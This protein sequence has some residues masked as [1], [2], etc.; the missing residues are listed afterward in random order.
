[1]PRDPPVTTAIFPSSD[2]DNSRRAGLAFQIRRIS[3]T[4][5][6]DRIMATVCIMGAGELGGAVAHALAQR[7]RVARVVLIDP[8]ARVAAG[9]ALDIQ[10]AGAVEGF[11]T[12][13]SGTDD[14]TQVTGCSICVLADRSGSPPS[15]WIGDEGLAMLNR[16]AGYLGRAPIVC[17]GAN[18][19][20]L[21]M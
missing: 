3:P 5:I 8:H 16:L 10:Q 7:E 1:M 12:R 13:L 19:A 9:K 14:V 2:I 17:A 20:S 18:Q 21:L 4:R 15:E 11:H 6:C